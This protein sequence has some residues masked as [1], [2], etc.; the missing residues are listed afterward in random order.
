VVQVAGHVGGDLSDA[1]GE[2]G[3]VQSGTGFIWDSAGHI[4]TNNHV[5]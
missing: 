5:V 3:G 4:V 2:E 1:A